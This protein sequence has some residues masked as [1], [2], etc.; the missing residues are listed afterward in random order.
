VPTKPPRLPAS[1]FVYPILD[2]AALGERAVEEVAAALV[3]GGARIVQVRAKEIADG[4]LLD[5]VRRAL[6]VVRAAGGALVVNDRPDVALIAGADGVHVGQDDLPPSE[7]RR[8]LGPAAIVGWSTH[9][10]DEL[11]A[12]AAQPVD[13][14]AVGPVFA[15]SSKADTAPVVGLD[16]VRA[17]RME[18]RLPLVGIGGITRANAASVVAAGA[19]GVCAIADLMRAPDVARAVAEMRAAVEGRG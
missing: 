14:A 6:R 17:A 15:T 5:A 10:L 3:T 8:L 4:A 12:A 18:T 16:L 7:C 13:Y 9:G 2:L 11:R 19:D 1:P